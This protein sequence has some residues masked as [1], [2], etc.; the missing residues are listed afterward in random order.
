[1]SIQV[2]QGRLR[3]A[4][5]ALCVASSA[6]APIAAEASEWNTRLWTGFE[7]QGETDLDGPGEF[8]YGMFVLG[9]RSSGPLD[10]RLGLVLRG[11]YR[12]IGYEFDNLGFD[13]WETVHVLRMNP[14]LQVRL[15]D[16][17]SL[18][19]GPIFEFSGETDADG[20]DSLRGGASFGVTYRRDATHPLRM[21]NRRRPAPLDHERVVA[22]WRAAARLPLPR[23]LRGGDRRRLPARALPP[24]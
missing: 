22:G 3:A 8:D 14:S 5:G 20:G 4:L 17:W 21:G 7:F 9:G 18:L 1:M 15:D 24:E 13:P 12:L 11:D 19:G 10:E 2:L 6:I 16:T 23:G